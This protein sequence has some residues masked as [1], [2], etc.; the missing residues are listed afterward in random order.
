MKDFMKNEKKNMKIFFTDILIIAWRE[1][2]KGIREK[3]RL[4]GSLVRLIIWLFLLGNGLRPSFNTVEGVD[5][6]H[7]IF[8][9]I[10]VMN[11]LFA[12]IISGISIIRDKEFGFLKEILVAP[13][14]RT[15]IALEKT[16]GGSLNTTVQGMI[17]LLLFPFIGFKIVLLQT[18]LSVL[19]MVFIGFCITSLGVFIAVRMKSF[20]GFGIMNNFV[21]LPIIFLERNNVP[22][23]QVPTAS[24]FSSL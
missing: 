8:P 20:E 4:D 12:G 2:I 15:S 1:I 10:I 6:I 13:V 11:I 17:V 22:D 9:G 19:S 18:V 5:Y 21:V 16:L 14:S 3:S 24:K 7:Y 23:R